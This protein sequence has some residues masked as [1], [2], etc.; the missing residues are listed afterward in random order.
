MAL[1]LVH[2]FP[3]KRMMASCLANSSSPTIDDVLCMN[4][5]Q[6]ILIEPS[7][8]SQTLAIHFRSDICATQ[9]LTNLRKLLDFA[10]SPRATTNTA[11]SIVG[12][13]NKFCFSKANN[14]RSMPI[15]KPIAGVSRAVE[16]PLPR[17]S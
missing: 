6:H 2:L 13:G 5:V 3:M 7:I 12:S 8:P 10:A 4:F 14:N 15:A 11:G 9:S 16:F 1:L 17:P